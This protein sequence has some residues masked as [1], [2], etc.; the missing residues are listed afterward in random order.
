MVS[1]NS[2]IEAET[3]EAGNIP[4]NI[5]RSAWVQQEKVNSMLLELNTEKKEPVQMKGK[6]KE[7][8]AAQTYT[9]FYPHSAEL[10]RDM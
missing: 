3:Y 9:V 1:R 7:D 2:I 10:C 8:M 6:A 4:V 5:T